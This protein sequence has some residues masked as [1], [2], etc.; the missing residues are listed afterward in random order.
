MYRIPIP[1][2]DAQLDCAANAPRTMHGR[3]GRD[4]GRLAALAAVTQHPARCGLQR[5][6]R[7]LWRLAHILLW[8][9]LLIRGEAVIRLRQRWHRRRHSGAR[10]RGLGDGGLRWRL[11]DGRL[12]GGRWRWREP[13]GEALVKAL[14]CSRRWRLVR[15][16]R[17][18]CPLPAPAREARR[19]WPDVVDES[20]ALPAA[21]TIGHGGVGGGGAGRGRSGRRRRLRLLLRGSCHRGVRGVSKCLR[22]C[23]REPH[24]ERQDGPPGGHVPPPAARI[25]PCAECLGRALLLVGHVEVGRQRPYAAAPLLL[26]VLLRRAHSPLHRV[27]DQ[28]R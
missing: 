25:P 15:L 19:V 14:L 18:R 10:R 20:E 5:R 3:L 23:S 24:S 26:L 4:P 11:R 7:Q 13:C 22:H 28:R 21:T 6:R 27:C 9:H 17:L 16:A 2:A 12:G 8:A 1:D